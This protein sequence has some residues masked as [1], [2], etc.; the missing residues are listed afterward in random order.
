MN[1]PLESGIQN[2]PSV[3]KY[4]IVLVV[5]VFISFLYPN[6]AKFKYEFEAGQTWRYDD[7]EAPFDF[8]IQKTPEEI[9]AEINR[10]ES[11][12][13]PFYEM[14]MRKAGERM[15]FFRE[16]F[17]NKLNEI[18]ADRQFEDVLRRAAH[19][20]EYMNG[21]IT[22]IYDQGVVRL[23][24]SHA[25]RNNNFVVN[26]RKGNTTYKQTLQQL[27][28]DDKIEKWL[29]DSLF[30]SGLPEADIFIPL[31]QNFFEPNLTFSDTLTAKFL[32]DQ[33]AAVARSRGMIRKGELIIA[34]GG[35]VTDDIYQ[36][37]ISFQK[38]YNQKVGNQKSH[39]G[40]LL[41]YFLLTC[42]ILGV[43][44]LYLQFHATQIFARFSS[45]IFLL[46]WP[47]LYSYLVYI[48]ESSQ[49]LSVYIIP[50]AIV[51]LIL[52]I[53][54]NGRLALFAHI[55]IVLL[56]SFLCSSGYEFAFLQI[57]AGIVA[58]LTNIQL[59]DWS[60]FF[61]SIFYIFLAY[62]LGYIGLS[63][64]ETGS[65]G[66]VDWSVYK[67]FF[68]NILLTLLAYPL[69]PLLERVFGFT[70]PITLVEWS[71][72]NRPLLKE[73]SLK[74]PGT[75][76]HSLQVGNL[77]EA[78]A[79]RIGAD[80]LLVKVA[81]LYHDVGKMNNSSYFI[82]N[83]SGSNPHQHL[84]ELESANII[85]GHVSEGVKIA[86]KHGLPE[87]LIDFI[88]THHGTTR[89]EYFYRNYQKK[90]PEEVFDERLFCYPGPRPKT[91]EQTI[92]MIADSLEAACRSRKELT[93]EGIDELVDKIIQGKIALHQFE[94]SELTFRELQTCKRAFKK[95]L[96]SI[97]HARI[98]YPEE[99]AEKDHTP[100]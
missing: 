96:K 60:K 6:N 21:L 36:N 50:F 4:L 7:L 80:P 10:I 92:L 58:V 41:G 44:I 32:T 30:N 53:F 82:E 8:A 42:L 93:E 48:V 24:P 34:N 81:A 84:N 70:S 65:L 31:L 73:L 91:R 61:L 23:E 16:N 43:F 46:L 28:T 17:N 35:I 37:L 67:Y 74:A 77:A 38:Q 69:I 29:P 90:H 22:R 68:L 11:D 47:A 97:F 72:M 18:R 66:E 3:V 89:V 26:I 5:V 99:N 49:V 19:Y 88:R 52:R 71:D 75:L 25:E 51:P 85:L 55:V 45:L 86:K 56:A 39:W 78:A 9:A 63:L 64:I 79:I 20:I 14:D 95:I 94:R 76:Q 2:L 87:I 15:R 62:A 33:K 57:L 59:R 98:E 1:N 27:Q 83:Q 13:S 12:A 54:F 100:S 40:V